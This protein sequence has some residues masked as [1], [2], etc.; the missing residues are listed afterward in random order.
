MSRSKMASSSWRRRMAQASS[1]RPSN[2]PRPALV[3]NFFFARYL[4]PLPKLVI[5]SSPK[6]AIQPSCGDA[7]G[8]AVDHSRPAKES[9]SAE[10]D[11]ATADQEYAVHTASPSS[12]CVASPSESPLHLQPTVPVPV[13]PAFARTSAHCRWLPCLPAL[14]PVARHEISSLHR[15]C[16]PAGVR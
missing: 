13:G 4:G 11:P 7:A 14:A 3:Q 8:A 1:P 6:F 12:A 16:V 9:R 10:N 15:F 5:D 2:S